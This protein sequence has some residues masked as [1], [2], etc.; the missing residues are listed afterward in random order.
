MLKDFHNLSVFDAGGIGKLLAVFLPHGL[1]VYT[2]FNI[3]KDSGVFHGPDQ[4]AIVDTDNAISILKISA[5]KLQH[6]ISGH[7]AFLEGMQNYLI[8]P[9]GRFVLRYGQ[10]GLMVVYDRV[11]DSLSRI[12][13]NGSFC[14]CGSI[15]YRADKPLWLENPFSPN[16]KKLAFG[17]E[18]IVNHRYDACR[19]KGG[20]RMKTDLR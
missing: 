11:T 1:Q 7:K 8:S 14:F 2:F 20:Y 12:E 3:S 6:Q 5:A 18:I 9:D 4:M 16:S 19:Q 13:A 10:S 15:I 17:E